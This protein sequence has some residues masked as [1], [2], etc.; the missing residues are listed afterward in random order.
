[1]KEECLFLRNDS[2]ELNSHRNGEFY[3]RDSEDML[4]AHCYTLSVMSDYLPRRRD[5]VD[6]ADCDGD[7]GCSVEEVMVII[8]LNSGMIM[9]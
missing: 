9:I 1:M 7:G 3:F 6:A 2:V 8:L 5:Q 4:R